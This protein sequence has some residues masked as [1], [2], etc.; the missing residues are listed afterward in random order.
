MEATVGGK[1]KRNYDAVPLQHPNAQY[2][3]LC[4][5]PF[6]ERGERLAYRL[7]EVAS[8]QRTIVGAPLVAKESRLI[9]ESHA[10]EDERKR[11]VRTFCSTQQI[12]RRIAAKF[13]ERLNS[14][15][16]VDQRTPRIR[17][18]DCSVYQLDDQ[19]QGKQSVLAEEK[20][21]H[22]SWTKWNANNGYVQGKAAPKYTEDTLRDAMKNLVLVEMDMI[23]EGSEEEEDDD[24]QEHSRLQDNTTKTFSP[25]EVAQA[26]SHFSYMSSGKKRLVCDLQGVFDDANNELIFSDPVIHYYNHVREDRSKVHGATDR[27]RKG[28]AMFFDTHHEHCGHLCRLVN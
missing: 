23:E 2:V 10:A 21:Y 28:I 1:L 8:D 25:F 17:F 6:G 26:F 13:N 24:E 11:F 3:A 9:L 5:E 27:G 16:R 14:L 18:L 20:I 4:K 7:F 12:A 15:K 22:S 19:Y